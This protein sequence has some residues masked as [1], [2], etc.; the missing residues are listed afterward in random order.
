ML[1]VVVVV[2]FDEILVVDDHWQEQL[3]LHKDL[4]VHL[5]LEVHRKDL[6]MPFEK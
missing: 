4:L 2:G 1:E 3:D 6:Q 5:Q